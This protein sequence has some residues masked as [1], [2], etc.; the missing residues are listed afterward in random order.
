MPSDEPNPNVY[1]V[2][3]P[4][5]QVKTHLSSYVA[6]LHELCIYGSNFLDNCLKD[7]SG[8]LEDEVILICFLRQF[9]VNLDAIYVLLSKGCGPASS[10]HLRVMLEVQI[11][12]KWMLKEDTAIRARHYIVWILRKRRRGNEQSDPSTEAGKRFQAIHEKLAK[13]RERASNPEARAKAAKENRMIDRELAKPEFVSINTSFEAKRN[14]RNFDSPWY[15][16]HD[17]KSIGELAKKVGMESEYA[18][19]YSKYSEDMHS[20]NFFDHRHIDESGAS[21]EQIRA[22]ERIDNVISIAVGISVEFFIDLLGH[23]R[24]DEISYFRTKYMIEWEKRHMN[25]PKVQLNRNIT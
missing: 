23:Y 11:Y 15:A 12:C 4:E 25:I 17:I 18:M 22:L 1:A 13:F 16:L 24:R 3:R 6:L 7:Q 8:K 19:L 10:I 20:T 2:A 5:E 21:I 9:L 14:K